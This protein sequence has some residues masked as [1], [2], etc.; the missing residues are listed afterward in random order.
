M[1]TSSERVSVF[2]FGGAADDSNS[3]GIDEIVEEVMPDVGS[4]GV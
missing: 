1:S 2:A 3:A 4:I